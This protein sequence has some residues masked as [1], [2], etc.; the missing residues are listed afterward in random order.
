MGRVLCLVG[1][2]HWRHHVNHEVGGP[3]P[4]T[5]CARG[6]H[7]EKSSYEGGNPAFTGLL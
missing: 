7:Q 5:T 6:C 2:H 4:A 1:I 3:A